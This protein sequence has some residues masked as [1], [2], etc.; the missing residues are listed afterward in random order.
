MNRNEFEKQVQNEQ[1]FYDFFTESNYGKYHCLIVYS[2]TNFRYID[3]WENEIIPYLESLQNGVGKINDWNSFEWG[4]IIC[5]RNDYVIILDKSIEQ[6]GR[7]LPGL[8][9]E[10][11]ENL[12]NDEGEW[13]LDTS[14]IE[15]NYTEFVKI[16]LNDYIHYCKKW[17]AILTTE[18]PA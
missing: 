12:Q 5:F 6:V 2:I 14:F 9:D 1:S 15:A 7:R 10:K 16:S 11:G 4:G 17:I 18:T 13:I 8:I 3:T